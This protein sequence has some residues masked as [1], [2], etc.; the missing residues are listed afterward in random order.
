MHVRDTAPASRAPAAS[1]AAAPTAPTVPGE[2]AKER[3]IRVQH[4]PF[5]RMCVILHAVVKACTQASAPSPVSCAREAESGL[6]RSSRSSW[7]QSGRRPATAGQHLR[8]SAS[9]RLRLHPP[10]R[11]QLL[12]PISPFRSARRRHGLAPHQGRA[13]TVLRHA[14]T[15]AAPPRRRLRRRRRSRTCGSEQ[16]QRSRCVARFLAG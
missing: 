15:A 9:W 14:Q 1:S 3:A 7:L 5:L 2:T 16:W 6:T 10:N 13:Q 11:Q 8:G 12:R 4:N